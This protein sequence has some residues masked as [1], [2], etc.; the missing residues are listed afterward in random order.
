MSLS[1]LVA[2]A[3]ALLASPRY[4]P[5][6]AAEVPALLRSAHVAELGRAPTPARL[7]MAVAQVR[8]EGLALCGRNLGAIGAGP[9]EP[10]CKVGGSRLRAWATYGEAAR[11]YWATL[12][13]R[14]SRALHAYDTGDARLVAG[15][16]ARCG[17]HRTPVAIYA[18]GLASFGRP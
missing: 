4:G 11:H 14:C 3:V 10:S 9:G 6:R 16:L 17:Y 13:A 5:L 8:L 7:A 18:A 1:A 12:R 2:V 15:L